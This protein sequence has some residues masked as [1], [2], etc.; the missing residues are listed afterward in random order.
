ML[1]AAASVTGLSLAC[2]VPA[3]ATPDMCAAYL[4][5]HGYGMDQYRWK[6]CYTGAKAEGLPECQRLLS[7]LESR[8]AG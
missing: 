3:S 6:A 2:A 5:S 8:Q 1:L 7:K 4:K